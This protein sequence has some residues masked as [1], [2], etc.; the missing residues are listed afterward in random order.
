MVVLSPREVYDSVRVGGKSPRS[1]WW[2]DKVY[3]TSEVKEAS[4][5]DFF[6][7]KD[8][9]MKK[10]YMVIYKEEKKRVKS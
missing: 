2:S 6:G 7:A 8:G 4:W 5:E 1:E 3:A 10:R 9:I